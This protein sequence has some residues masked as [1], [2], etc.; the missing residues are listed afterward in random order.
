MKTA[1]K[2]EE[3]IKDGYLDKDLLIKEK[4]VRELSK[5]LR[6]LSGIEEKSG[7]TIPLVDTIGMNLYGRFSCQIKDI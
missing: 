1:K 6:R 4:S 3:L 7:Y 5:S 2:L